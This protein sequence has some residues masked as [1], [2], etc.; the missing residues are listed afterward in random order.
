L[1]VVAGFVF[2]VFVFFFFFFSLRFHVKGTKPADVVGVQCAEKASSLNSMDC[3]VLVAPAAVYSWQGSGATDAEKE[4][5]VKI[6]E[7]LKVT[8]AFASLLFTLYTSFRGDPSPPPPPPP[9][10]PSPFAW[11]AVVRAHEGWLAGWL[12]WFGLVR[13]DDEEQR[14][15]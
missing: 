2:I 6:A 9:A 3:F 15:A 7:L 12:V 14:K 13:A 10:M 1:V 4:A 5:G 8:A 11:R